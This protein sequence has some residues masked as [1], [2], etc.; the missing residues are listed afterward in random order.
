MIGTDLEAD[1][2]QLDGV[3]FETIDAR[4][5]L[6]GQEIAIDAQMRVTTRPR[7]FGQLGVHAFAVHHQRRQQTNVLAFEVF[8]Q[9][10][11]NA[12]GRLR[13]HGGVVVNAMLRA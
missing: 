4:E 1:H 7:P 10:R 5:I 11:G 8:H 6:R 13:G 2:R 9:L 3:L 12:V